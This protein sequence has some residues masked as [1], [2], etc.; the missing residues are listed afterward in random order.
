MVQT[1]FPNQ[2]V[3]FYLILL[4]KIYSFVEMPV[5][6]IMLPFLSCP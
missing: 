2:L 4:L 6:V 1:V 3:M 5:I